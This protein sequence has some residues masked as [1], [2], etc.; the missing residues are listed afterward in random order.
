MNYN[1]YLPVVFARSGYGMDHLQDEIAAAVKNQLSGEWV[2]LREGTSALPPD[3]DKLA[4]KAAAEKAYAAARD[5]IAGRPDAYRTAL[6][7]LEIGSKKCLV[8]NSRVETVY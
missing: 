6:T 1:A 8:L 4:S 2:P 7:G 5:Y 3:A